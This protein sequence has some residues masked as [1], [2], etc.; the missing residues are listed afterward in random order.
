MNV[1]KY[2]SP[3]LCAVLFAVLL[4][5]AAEAARPFP[6][7]AA[8]SSGRTGAGSRF[9]RPNQPRPASHKR[10]N[11][12]RRPNRQ[13]LRRRSSN[14]RV[15]LKS[16]RTSVWD[17]MARLGQ[18]HSVTRRVDFSTGRSSRRRPRFARYPALRRRPGT[19]RHRRFGD[20]AHPRR[21][22]RLES[23]PRIRKN[24]RF[25]HRIFRS[26]LCLTYGQQ[27]YYYT[28]PYFTYFYYIRPYYYSIPY[29]SYFDKGYDGQTRELEEYEQPARK[30]KR[31]TEK[32]E[33][34][35][36]VA[37]V[38]EYL[39]RVA[40]SFASGDY[41][42]AVETAAEAIE[43]LPDNTVLLFIYS[44]SLFADGQYDKAAE[45]LQ[46]ALSNVDIEADGVFYPIGFYP[47]E[48]I[49]T[50]Q[51]TTLAEVADAKLE[52]SSLQLL[53]G[54]QLLGIGDYDQALGALGSAADSQ[55]TEQAAEL[56]M[57]VLEKASA[58]SETDSEMR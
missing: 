17:D 33:Q 38:N 43:A 22:W 13:A 15:R 29:R 53:L 25:H 35:S 7:R 36:E 54:Y 48:D 31:P 1:R 14:I 12:Y 21:R 46:T 41:E 45:V 6:A 52:N 49:L 9:A 56:L 55:L 23:R 44:Q 42:Q 20:R 58:L 51:I 16:A 37:V 18:S 32:A 28:L 5:P 57:E 39:S 8:K 19:A 2:I 40:K 4:V 26:G 50:E 34:P 27:F 30:F 11:R 24:L 10:F 3:A 47:D